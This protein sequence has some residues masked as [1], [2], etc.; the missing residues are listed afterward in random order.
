MG[1][2]RKLG[3]AAALAALLCASRAS[4]GTVVEPIAR[5][6]LE[7]GYDT[8][9]LYDGGS[10]DRAGRISPDVGVRLHA[11]RWDLRTT[12]GGEYVYYERLA[13]DGVWNHRGVLFLDA[14]P[15]RRT[16]VDAFARANQTEDPAGLAAA[17]VFRAGRERALLLTGRGQLAWRASRRVEAAVTMTE[18]M[19]RFDDGSG[20][21]MHA[22]TVESLWRFGR[23]LSLGAAYAFGVFQEFSSAAAD[24]LA[25]SHGLRARGRWQLARHVAVNASAGPAVWI[26][27]GDTEIVPEAMVEV[28]VA[29]RGFDLRASA[30]HTLGIGAS[31]NPGLVDSAEF[32]VERRF[33]RRYVVRGDGGLWRSG[34]IPGGRDAETGYVLAGEA[35][36]LFGGLRL[37]LTGAHHDRV[38][39]SSGVFRRTLVGIRL[40]WEAALRVR[41][42]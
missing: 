10:G 1:A 40:G 34:T 38:D 5:L 33:A 4:A 42:R 12:Y 13:P 11:P 20:G 7:G 17:G 15:T 18:R 21:A 23:R 30:G 31:A 35:G 27:S 6:Y 8:N 9:P 2:W 32:G 3:E 25:F 19:V 14:R 24:E 37:S 29:T 22:P 28:L 16:R 41:R 26:P 39:D 36:I